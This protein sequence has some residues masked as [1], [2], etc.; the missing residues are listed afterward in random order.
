MKGKF[1]ER[2]EQESDMNQCDAF[3]VGCDKVDADEMVKM[4]DEAQEVFP[5]NKKWKT[6]LEELKHWRK[7]SLS[8]QSRAVASW[9]KSRIETLEWVV[10]WFGDKTNDVACV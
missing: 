9:I 2:I 6:P 5:H 4:I 7:V 3:D 8:G 1:K 10:E